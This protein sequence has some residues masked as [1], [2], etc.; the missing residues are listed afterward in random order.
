MKF[1]Y[2]H[3]LN[4]AL[5]A[6]GILLATTV[7]VKTE[8]APTARYARGENVDLAF[9]IQEWKRKNPKTPVFACICTQAVCD[10]SKAWPFRKFTKYQFNVALGDFNAAN[11]NQK[12]GFKCHEIETGRPPKSSS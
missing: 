11:L 7:P 4:I 1:D 9:I 12:I 6:T 5:L 10:S 3:S 8:L 2:K